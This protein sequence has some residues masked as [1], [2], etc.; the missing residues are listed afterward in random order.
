MPAV[1]RAGVRSPGTR[2]RFTTMSQSCRA[3]SAITP[4]SPSADTS[5][6]TM[7]LSVP[8]LTTWWPSSTRRAASPEAIRAMRAASSANPGVAASPSATALPAIAFS[9]GAPW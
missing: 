9:T 7:W 3:R 5:S 1:T 8:P 6:S 4:V 2:L